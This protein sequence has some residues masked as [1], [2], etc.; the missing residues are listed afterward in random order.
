MARATGLDNTQG[1]L[2]GKPSAMIRGNSRDQCWGITPRNVLP[3]KPSEVPRMLSRQ[4]LRNHVAV[5]AASV[6]A[7][8]VA[9]PIAR[10]AK[11]LAVE[12]CR[13]S[14]CEAF[15]GAA[16]ALAPPLATDI[17]AVCV[18]TSAACS[19][20]EMFRDLSQERGRAT[21]TFQG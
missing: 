7:R 14:C 11:T 3:R 1:K 19:A 10:S 18:A 2:C 20:A 6:D 5:L 17:A 9:T 16:V 4:A 21:C 13:D 8:C 12:E 15:H